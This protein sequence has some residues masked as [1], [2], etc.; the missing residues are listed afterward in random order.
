MP[1]RVL[2]T[3]PVHG[4][5]VLCLAVRFAAMPLRERYQPVDLLAALATNAV[6]HFRALVG[7]GDRLVRE[8]GKERL[9][10]KHDKNVFFDNDAS[11]LIIAELLVENEPESQVE[12][13][14]ALNIL[15][16]QIDEYAHGHVDFSW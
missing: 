10:Q 3:V 13:S 7:I 6:E 16:G 4:A 1:I 8:R 5:E 2:E 11:R 15:N 12:R 9:G 14:R